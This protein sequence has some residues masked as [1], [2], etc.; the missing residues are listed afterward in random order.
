MVAAQASVTPPAAATA[1]DPAVEKVCGDVSNTP[2][3]YTCLAERQRNSVRAQIAPQAAP[4][5]LGP[6]DLKDAY[7]LPSGTAGA[8]QTVAIIDAFD[9]PKAESDLATYR[10]QFGLPACTTANGCFR[11]VNQNGQASPLPKAD[12]GWAGEIALDID[13]VSAVCPLCKILL[14]ESNGPDNSL[15]TAIDTAARLGAKFISNSWGGGESTNQDAFDQQHL[16]KPG[17]AITA[18]SGDNGFGVI[19]PASSRFV[20]AVGG[21]SLRRASNTRGWSETAWSGAG[22]GCATQ[23]PKP[24]WQHDTGCARKTV[25]DVS[26][27]ADPAT[28]VAVFLTFGGGGWTVFGGTS[29][30]APIIAS[31]YAL[32]GTPAANTTSCNPAYLCTGGPGFDGPTGLGTPNGVAAFTAGSSQPPPPPNHF[33]A[34]SAQLSQATV[35]TNHTGYSGT[36]FVDY[37]NVAGSFVQ[38]TVP[39]TAAGS[40][41]LRIRYANGTTANRPM[42]ITV[43]GGAPVTVNFPGTGSWN[44]WATATVTVNLSAGNNAVRAT[45]TGSAGGPNVDWLE[46]A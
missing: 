26:A 29:A 12:S 25:A 39:R 22:S 8:G 27:V 41:T 33:E 4:A 11:K 3:R 19:H 32:A 38:W 43:G 9:D 17:V 35:A 40:A 13:M 5:G 6:A 24:P 46:V 21:T 36:G 14:V 23:S 20:T 44:T 31:V 1:T 42:T 7:K 30:S 15:F 18:S 37:A 45:A 16:N 2:G 34:E 10:S 28:G